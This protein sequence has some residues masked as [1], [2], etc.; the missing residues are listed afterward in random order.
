MSGIGERDDA[1]EVETVE[2]AEIED[3]VETPSEDEG[4]DEDD[5]PDEAGDEPADGGEGQPAA[6][7]AKPRSAA[8]IAVQEAKR[9]AKEAKA[10]AEATRREL[11]QLR[12]AS[13]G[14]QTAEQQELERQRLELMP[15]EEK[16][17]YLLNKQAEQTRTQV[18]ALQFQMQDATDRS[19]FQSLAAR[20]DD[21]GKAY[22]SVA[23]DV[24]ARL[25][26][27]RASGQP[28]PA[29]EV[30]AKYL[31]GERAVARMARSKPKQAAKGAA[32]IAANTVKP[33]SGRSDVQGGERRG[34]SDR[35]AR[36][37]RL[38]DMEI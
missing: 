29:R 38:G 23:D 7:A 11:E 31:I 13:Q 18:G 14:R 4:A 16:F 6:V 35:A 37:A 25:R 3:V 8:T 1:P 20:P 5:Q 36:A 34:G 9:A 27:I 24:E 33:A 12:Q 10:E 30:I 32:R 22:A 26:E 19:V 15:P 2:D 17:T 28:G 21:I